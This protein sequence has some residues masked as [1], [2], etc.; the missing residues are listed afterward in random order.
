MS[1]EEIIRM[2]VL[3]TIWFG[4]TVALFLHWLVKR[5]GVNGL[6]DTCPHCR[7]RGQVF[8]RERDDG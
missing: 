6:W 7:G 4:I 2:E 1:I 3:W 5:E 8:Y